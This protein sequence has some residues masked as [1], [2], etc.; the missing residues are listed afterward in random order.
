YY[1]YKD[2]EIVETDELE[3]TYEEQF[4][5]IFDLYLNNSVVASTLLG[6]KT[7]D[8]SMTEFA[9]GQSAMV[10]NGNWAWGQIA[11]FD[12]NIVY[13]EDI[14]FLPIYTGV[15]GEEKQGIRSE[16]HTS[17]LQS[18]FDLV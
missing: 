2:K 14:G 6:S 17:E 5:N 16:E 18:R 9:L 8:D 12:G 4:A 10:Q 11:N 7:T 13:E 3:F 1:E 15:D